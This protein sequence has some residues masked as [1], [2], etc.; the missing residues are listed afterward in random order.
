MRQKMSF[1][2]MRMAGSLQRIVQY[3]ACWHNWLIS[4]LKNQANDKHTGNYISSMQYFTC[5]VFKLMGAGC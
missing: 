4:A 3:S 5:L 1:A 2:T